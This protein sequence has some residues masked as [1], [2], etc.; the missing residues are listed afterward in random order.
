[1]IPLA[2]SL[3]GSRCADHAAVI[4]RGGRNERCILRV[5]KDLMLVIAD[6]QK[7]LDTATVTIGRSEKIQAEM[8]EIVKAIAASGRTDQGRGSGRPR[9]TN[10]KR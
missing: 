5:E 1:M 10:R 2:A 8:L 7:S 4:E 3:N 9:G 6:L